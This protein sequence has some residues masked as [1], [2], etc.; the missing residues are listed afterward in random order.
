MGQNPEQEEQ[1]EEQHGRPAVRLPKNTAA[2]SQLDIEAHEASGHAVYRSWCPACVDSRAY[3]QGHKPGQEVV[4]AVP[5]TAA[6]YGYLNASE[7]DSIS[8]ARLAHHPMIVMHDVRPPGTGCYFATVV[9]Q[10][11]KDDWVATTAADFFK[12]VGHARAVFQSD[13]ESPL[14]A[15]KQQIAEKASPTELVMRESPVGDHK[16][17]G[18]SEN[19]VKQIKGRV[20]SM[21]LG[22]QAH[23]GR[24]LPF[25]HPLVVWAPRHAANVINRYVL[26][27]DGKTAEERRTGRRWE[28]P[29]IAYAER[30]R[31]R[32]LV[33]DQRKRDLEPRFLEGL[34]I[35]HATRS[36]TVFILTKEGVQRGTTVVRLPENQRWQWHDDILEMRGLPWSWTGGEAA[37]ARAAADRAP[38][39][40]AGAPV[41]VGLP[42]PRDDRDLDFYVTRASVE[43]A[44]P[45]D[46]CV[47]CEQLVFT[48]RSNVAHTAACR[49]RIIKEL[50]ARGDERLRRHRERK[51]APPAAPA[52]G[53][54]PGGGGASAAAVP[55]RPPQAARPGAAVR[56]ARDAEG[57]ARPKARRQEEAAARVPGPSGARVRARE[58]ERG[59]PLPGA[60]R[61]LPAPNAR[62]ELGV[63][64]GAPGRGRGA[65]RSPGRGQVAMEVDGAGSAPSAAPAQPALAGP[66]PSTAVAAVPPTP[67]PGPAGPAPTTPGLPWPAM[68]LADALS[69]EEVLELPLELQSLAISEYCNPGVFTELCGEFGLQPGIVADWTIRD[70]N[71]ERMDMS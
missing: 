70:E 3:G 15:L 43:A 39:Q 11:G 5:L 33:R 50:E 29:A 58:E 12:H 46:G 61:V 49:T 45:T 64:S 28:K 2:P 13:G 44:G 22:A 41:V 6:D 62:P 38:A 21:L 67:P 68:A 24:K 31:T 7:S 47:A 66:A 40:E 34:Y 55:P 48:G 20:R 18:A 17:N 25:Q 51:G 16:A 8:D 4:S 65:P 57:E 37:V 63:A 30:I 10:K 23:W 59:F 60:P 52:E 71:G 35:G 14:L 27:P 53:A 9:P 36:A 56:V 69:L 32:A 54:S 19:A 1:E 26:G 42:V